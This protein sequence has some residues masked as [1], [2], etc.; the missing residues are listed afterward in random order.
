MLYNVITVNDIDFSTAPRAE[1]SCYKWGDGYQPVAY[2]QLVYVDGKG[3]ALHMHCDEKD[4]KAVY[5]NYNDPVYKD[6]CLEFF[7]SFNANSPLYMNFEMNS[8]GAFLSAVRAD[9]KSKTPIDKLCDIP[10]VKAHR[11]ADGWDVDVF[12]S[13]EMIN[14][15]FGECSFAKGS[16]FKGNFYK[17]GDE[18]PRPHF[19]M[20]SPVELPSP[21]FHRPEFFGELKII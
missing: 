15:L 20:W 13:L 4:P 19:G 6:S 21:D 18:T 16:V 12:F 9:R 17:C 11:G 14:K 5:N 8:N 3:F 1:I 7:V 2:A 10:E